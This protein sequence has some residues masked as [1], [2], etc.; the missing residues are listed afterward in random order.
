M[1]KNSTAVTLFA[2]IALTGMLASAKPTAGKKT[3]PAAPPDSAS[4]V[5]SAAPPSASA[6]APSSSAPAPASSSD[7][8]DAK[9]EE[10]RAHFEKGIRIF[11]EGAWDAALVEF[12]R[13]RELYATR[14]ATKNAALCLRKLHRFDE[15]LE[16]NESLIQDF[17]NLPPEDKAAAEREL[18]ELTGMVGT[19]VLRGAEPGSKVVI[20]SRERGTVPIAQLRASAGT[21]LVRVTKEGF[22]PFETQLQVAGGQTVT[23]DVRLSALLQGGRLRVAEQ[24]GKTLDVV[25]DNVVVG[26]T[27]WEGTL[28]VGDHTVLLRGAGEVGT[29]PASAPVRLNQL[30]PITLVAE[31][32]E[33]Q[34]RVEPTPASATVAVDGVS[35]G[36][37][38]WDGRV[39]AGGHRIE[40]GAEGF[41]PL[42][43][44]LSLG[45][46]KREVV[47][48]RLERDPS[49]PLWQI[50]HPSR[51]MLE[52]D[53]GAA[54][55]PSLGGSLGDACKGSCSKSVGIGLAAIARGGYRFGSGIGLSIDGGYLML[56]QKITGAEGTIMPAGVEPNRGS[57]ND[58]LRLSGVLLG[59]S[60]G[61]FSSGSWPFTFRLGVGALLGTLRDQRTGTFATNPRTTS[62]GQTLPAVSYDVNISESPSARYL[63]LAPEARIGK[64]FGDRFELSVGLQGM[65]LVAFSQPKWEDKKRVAAA[66]D[67]VGKFG[68]KELTGRTVVLL[69]PSLGARYDF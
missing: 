50:A 24:T 5:A 27:P 21:R 11:G 13:S 43:R 52:A 28:P 22:S 59:A 69:V 20:D 60:A 40:V 17:P 62:G 34:L 48:A 58:S 55:A 54:I 16:M 46:D 2:I 47:T 6:P 53:V 4:A 37:G 35:V 44:E 23:V 9:K 49:S 12:A 45:K 1:R 32:L 3:T 7:P 64:R 38:V 31:K 18:R 30:T 25:V 29:Q 57:Q 39:R 10:S 15:A 36:R 26:Q 33:S 41:L 14:A 42:V 61:Y 65:F 51:V 19:I 8:S 68:S 56:A 63:Y 66:S 67:G